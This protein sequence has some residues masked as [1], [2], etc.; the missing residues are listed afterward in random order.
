MLRVVVCFKTGLITAGTLTKF[1]AANG[2]TF[3][4]APPVATSAGSLPAIESYIDKNAQTYHCRVSRPGVDR[5]IIELR[6]PREP[7]TIRGK[8]RATRN[9]KDVDSHYQ[10]IIYGLFERTFTLPEGVDTEQLKAEYRNGVLELPA[11]MAA[12]GLPRPA[13]ANTRPRSKQIAA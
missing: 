2:G 13:P 5:R 8:R 11:P 9:E 1:L 12:A 7:V 10:E 4:K 6:A 3:D